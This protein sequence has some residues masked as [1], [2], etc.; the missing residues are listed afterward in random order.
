MQSR[1][2]SGWRNH[3]EELQMQKSGRALWWNKLPRFVENETDIS[4]AA[5]ILMDL[6]PCHE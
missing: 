3:L 2:A 1:Y 4:A 5:Q 6:P